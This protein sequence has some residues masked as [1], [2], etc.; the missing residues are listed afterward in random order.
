MTINIYDETIECDVTQIETYAAVPTSKHVKVHTDRMATDKK[1]FERRPS[2]DATYPTPWNRKWPEFMMLN[3][4]IVDITAIYDQL[5]TQLPQCAFSG[6]SQTKKFNF[7][8]VETQPD[9]V[10]CRRPD[11]LNTTIEYE[12]YVALMATNCT[13]HQLLDQG[14]VKDVNDTVNHILKK[15]RFASLTT[16]QMYQRKTWSEW[17]LMVSIMNSI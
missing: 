9:F 15:I 11:L 16:R 3:G 5:K 12:V 10:Y 14:L 2:S 1:L 6:F 7:T 17:K 8:C 13:H 4:N